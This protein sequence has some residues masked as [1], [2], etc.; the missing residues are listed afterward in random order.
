MK[1]IVRRLL[2]LEALA[3][4]QLNERGETRAD[5]LRARIRRWCEASGE[6]FEELPPESFA[7]AQTLG[8]ILRLGR[9]RA[10]ESK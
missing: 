7:G 6:P 2:R 10:R 4:P 3:T 8:E 1:A 9:Q 5:V